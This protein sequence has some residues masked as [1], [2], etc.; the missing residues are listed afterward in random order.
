MMTE[1]QIR[2]FIEWTEEKIRKGVSREEALETLVGA[3]ILDWDGNYTKPYREM[4]NDAGID[5]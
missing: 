4:L 5:A 3:G 1:K 2:E